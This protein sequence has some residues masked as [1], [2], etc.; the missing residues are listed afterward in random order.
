M[1]L[2]SFME[3]INESEHTDADFIKRV[4]TF[5]LNKVKDSTKNESQEYSVSAKSEFRSPFEFDLFLELRRDSNPDLESDSHFSG[6]SWEITNFNN[7][8]YCIDANV[9]M[10]S[11]DLFIPEITIHL[12]LNPKKEPLSYEQLFY[13]LIDILTHETNHLNQN[14]INRESFNVIPSN[15]HERNSAKKSYKYFLLPDEIESMV[16]GMYAKS[17]ESGKELDLIFIDYLS[18]FIKNGFMKESEFNKVV[19]VWI[20]KALE[21]YPDANFS[22]RATKIINSI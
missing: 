16:E 22:N 2:K 20:K 5:L 18:P 11:G 8:G 13:R 15:N 9:K 3:F 4:A 6:L 17:K 19:T 21:L 7:L 10:N 14:G 1:E 12:I